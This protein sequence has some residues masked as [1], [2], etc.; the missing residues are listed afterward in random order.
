M[1]TTLEDGSQATVALED[2]GGAVVLGDGFMQQLKVIQIA[3]PFH[4]TIEG[5]LC[6]H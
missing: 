4:L 1:D 5:L 2:G 6:R 3:L